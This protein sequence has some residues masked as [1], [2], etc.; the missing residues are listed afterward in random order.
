M[1]D[2]MFDR[3]RAEIVAQQMR[4][5]NPGFVFTVAPL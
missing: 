4:E 5:D 2:K 3:E 1:C